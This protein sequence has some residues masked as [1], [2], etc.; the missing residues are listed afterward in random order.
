M[1]FKCWRTRKQVSVRL[2]LDAGEGLDGHIRGCKRCARELDELKRLRGHLENMP[3][4]SAPDGF[5]AR[6][7]R[8]VRAA[9]LE[10]DPPPR[11]RRVFAY[12]AEAL[13]IV[14]VVGAGI[15]SGNYLASSI[16]ND[17]AMYGASA[18]ENLD[19]QNMLYASAADNLDI[20]P[21]DPTEDY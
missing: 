13:A 20:T 4:Y 9:R 14:I 8:Q 19:S 15:V 2:D 16:F 3:V 21:A 17:T 6:V 11:G 12:F 10:K 18:A 7:M 5:S 1:R